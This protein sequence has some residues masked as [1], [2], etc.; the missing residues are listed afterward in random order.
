MKRERITKF[1]WFVFLM[2]LSTYPVRAQWKVT[3]ELGMSINAMEY[4]KRAG[5]RAG[6]GVSYELFPDLF[7]IQSGLLFTTVFM[8]SIVLPTTSEQY[9]YS[10]FLQEARLGYL[11][12]PVLA[13]LTLKVARRVRF[14]FNAGPYVAYGVSGKI[15]YPYSRD[16]GSGVW[17]ADG[18]FTYID[19]V[20]NTPLAQNPYEKDYRR[21]GGG[22]TFGMG[23]QFG[24]VIFKGSY[25]LGLGNMLVPHRFENM[26][27]PYVEGEYN[28]SF[29]HRSWNVSIGVVIGKYKK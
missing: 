12:L 15:D 24:R 2:W 22:F 8:S 28:P 20:N 3:P 29:Q 18:T 27:L 7:S 26:K 21:W 16:M 23:V 9:P 11:R 25:D 10:W 17:E 19:Y 14:H 13:N 6:V 5:F 4:N 1:V